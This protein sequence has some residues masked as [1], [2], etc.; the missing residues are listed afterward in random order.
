MTTTHN[1]SNQPSQSPL[2]IILEDCP[3]I[4]NWYKPKRRSLPTDPIIRKR[5]LQDLRINFAYTVD[6]GC[7]FQAAA[8][9]ETSEGCEVR[10]S[11]I[12]ALRDVGRAG[13]GYETADERVLG[14]GV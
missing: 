11:G 7:W 4:R 6:L 3:L 10:L 1:L 5:V 12:D 8:T 2:G 9:N 14:V 13:V